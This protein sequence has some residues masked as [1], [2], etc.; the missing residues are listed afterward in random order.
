MGFLADFVLETASAPGTAATF[1]LAGAAT[2]RVSFIAAFTSGSTVFYFIDDGAQAE[3]GTGVITAGSP[4]T[5][6][7]T[8]V[9]G[10][11]AGTTA[12]L[13]FTGSVRVYNSVPSARMPLLDASGNLP[14][15]GAVTAASATLSGALSAA[16][17][18]ISGTITAAAATISGAVSAASAAISGA[19]TAASA[20]ISGTVS[21]AAL[22]ASGAVTAA[23]AA[24]TGTITAGLF[25]GKGS[26][27]VGGL[28]DI[29]G[30]TLPAGWL[31]ANGAAV[32]RTTYA[33]LFAA[34]GTTWGNGDGS[35]TF[36]VPNA[37]EVF[38]LGRSGM[39]GVAARSL[40]TAA[41]SGTNPATLGAT[42]G[43]ERMQQ[44]LHT[45]SQP[46]HTH[47]VS[48]VG[49]AG[50][51]GPNSGVDIYQL[52]NTQT[53]SSVQP[54]ITVANAGAG[55]TQNMPPFGV[56]NVVIYAGV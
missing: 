23:S 4:N 45:A 36:N 16:S 19:I 20:S 43:D 34:I 48:G 47:T 25:S 56:Y 49:T 41:I 38:R 28:M 51:S 53:T 13:N 39:N 15:T 30:T 18:A 9:I 37:A 29:A 22:T 32:S 35:T 6:T 2:G 12:R 7:R 31:W 3:W 11:T 21:A 26:T 52:G 5:F 40:V 42:G 24:I 27:P 46:P 55:A 17:A 50:S 10:N 54:A 33:A 8:T 1:N 44:H 14:V